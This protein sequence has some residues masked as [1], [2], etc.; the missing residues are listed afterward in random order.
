MGILYNYRDFQVPSGHL[1]VAC[2]LRRVLDNGNYI[3]EM[4]M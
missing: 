3:C 1:M 2:S 4:F